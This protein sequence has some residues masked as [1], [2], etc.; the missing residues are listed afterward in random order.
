[1]MHT[2]NISGNKIEDATFDSP[3]KT[4]FVIPEN[5]EFGEGLLSHQ[6]QSDIHNQQNKLTIELLEKAIVHVRQYDSLETA[7]KIV[8]KAF[9]KCPSMFNRN[10]IVD[11]QR[12]LKAAIKADKWAKSRRRRR[13]VDESTVRRNLDTFY[14]KVAAAVE[15]IRLDLDK[16]SLT[17]FTKVKKQY[18][19]TLPLQLGPDK[20][21]TKKSAH[22]IVM[23][24]SPPR[25]DKRATRLEG[26]LF[27]IED[28]TL[29]GVNRKLVKS[30]YDYAD[31]LARRS[32]RT[33]YKHVLA[34]PSDN[35]DWYLVLDFGVDISFASF[36]DKMEVE[37][38]PDTNELSFE[39]YLKRQSEEKRAQ[40]KY[41]TK[42]LRDIRQAFIE[43]NVSFFEDLKTLENELDNVLYERSELAAEFSSL[44]VLSGQERGLEISQIGKLYDNSIDYRRQLIQEGYDFDRAHRFAIKQRLEAKSCWYD[45][46]DKSN[47]AKQI[48]Q[49]IDFLKTEL[50]QRKLTYARKLGLI[51]TTKYTPDEI[52]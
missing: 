47:R 17:L 30:T 2:R 7:T 12:S 16:R 39:G 40:E 38:N 10:K 5:Q 28:V 36:A 42:R 32:G 50:E 34:R 26:N 31:G 21:A 3:L 19:S 41:K 9:H 4:D 51:S 27:L 20:K 18:Q 52:D 23:C 29:V 15:T 48:R 43:D 33:I 44:T 25:G 46:Q 45:Y 8:A 22:V 37:D 13:H 11:A 24:E 14:E 35:I 6:E 49:R 1:M